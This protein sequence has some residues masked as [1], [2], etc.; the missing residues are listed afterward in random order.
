MYLEIELS[1][2][3]MILSLRPCKNVSPIHVVHLLKLDTNFRKDKIPLP[4]PKTQ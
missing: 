1:G 3:L 2:E 4:H